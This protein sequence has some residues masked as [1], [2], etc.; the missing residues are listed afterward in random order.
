MKTSLQY[1][2]MAVYEISI[3][4]LINF[5][6]Y[7]CACCPNIVTPQLIIDNSVVNGIHGR[8]AQLT[9]NHTNPNSTPI[10]V[11]WYKNNSRLF[12]GEKYTIS[13]I[14]QLH[15]Y[16]LQ[17]HNVTESDEGIYS[18]VADS[19]HSSKSVGHI[20]FTGN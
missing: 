5:Y 13:V 8:S 14:Q 18:C 15:S 9:C 2:D 7:I 19:L 4:L 17:V 10:R 12:T 16:T 6:G 1:S 3:R 20:K 11:R